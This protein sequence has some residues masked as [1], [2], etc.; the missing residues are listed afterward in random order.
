MDLGLVWSSN[1]FVSR[2]NEIAKAAPKLSSL[3]DFISSA[4]RKYHFS[5]LKKNTFNQ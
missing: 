2:M 5:D 4:H 3:N 1:R